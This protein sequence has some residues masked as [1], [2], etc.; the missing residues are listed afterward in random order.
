MQPNLSLTGLPRCKNRGTQHRY[1]VQEQ[2]LIDDF[3]NNRLPIPARQSL[4][5]VSQW[6][7]SRKRYVQYLVN[8]QA[9]HHALESS[10]AEALAVNEGKSPLLS[11]RCH[12]ALLRRKGISALHYLGEPHV[13]CVM[14][15]RFV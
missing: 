14:Q 11:A 4:P 2:G 1:R 3:A 5:D 7:L 15:G 6:S 13:G 10:V 8:Q 9:V 12:S